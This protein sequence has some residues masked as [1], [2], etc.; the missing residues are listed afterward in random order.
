LPDL[1]PGAARAIRRLL[2]SLLLVAAQHAAAMHALGHAIEHVHAGHAT[3]GLHAG[4]PGV[5]GVG[6]APVS[7]WAPP[8][9][10]PAASAPAHAPARR[11][12]PAPAECPYLSRAPPSER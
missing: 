7:G 4:C 1:H 10:S 11:A 9:A 2:L 5:H 3:H 8:A 6:D 12:C